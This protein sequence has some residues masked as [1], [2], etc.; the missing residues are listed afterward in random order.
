MSCRDLPV[1]VHLRFFLR[2]L[3]AAMETAHTIFLILV[4]QILSMRH[5]QIIQNCFKL[6]ARGLLRSVI[7]DS[8]FDRCL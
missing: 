5:I 8:F 1:S 2:P 4:G 3:L 6:C 7:S